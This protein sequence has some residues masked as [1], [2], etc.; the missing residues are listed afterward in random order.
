MNAYTEHQKKAILAVLKCKTCGSAEDALQAA[1]SA[2]D[3]VLGGDATASLQI[4]DLQNLGVVEMH[5]RTAGDAERVRW[6][7]TGAARAWLRSETRVWVECQ[8]QAL[9]GSQMSM[10]PIEPPG[11]TDLQLARFVSGDTA[12]RKQMLVYIRQSIKEKNAAT[13]IE[14]SSLA[15]FAKMKRPAGCHLPRAR[16]AFLEQ[17]NCLRRK[18]LGDERG[19][20]P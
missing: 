12:I 3:Y 10:P 13:S 17:A 20:V 8:V 11:L 16:L 4:T 2:M 7:L 5:I 14:E 18:I 9:G 19:A 15:S 1:S 6:R